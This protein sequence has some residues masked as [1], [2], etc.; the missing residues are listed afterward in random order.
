YAPGEPRRGLGDCLRATPAGNP[1]AKVSITSGKTGGAPITPFYVHKPVR[2]TAITALSYV[3]GTHAIKGGMELSRGTSGLQRNFQNPNVNFYERYHDVSGGSV[4]F[5]VTI[6]NTPV[7]EFDH[8]NAD[9]GMFLQDTW[10]LKRLTL[11]P[12]IRWEYFKASY[13]DEGVSVQQQALMISEGYNARPLFPG[14]TMPIFKNWAPR[15]G[16]SYDV[17]GNGKTAVKASVNKY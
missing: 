17:F 7:E 3:T 12:G 8:L 9:L 1:I 11:T 4:P 15:F 6:Y 10:T 16:A 5:Q 2:E 14:V 13:P